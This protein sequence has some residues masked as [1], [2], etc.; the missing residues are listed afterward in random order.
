M[1][2]RTP[3][4]AFTLIELLV[5]IAIIAVL[6]G[7]LIP[8]VQKVRSAA[9]RIR[10]ANNLKQIGLA[11]HAHHDAQN[12]FPAGYDNETGWG[13]GTK[14]LPYLEQTSLHSQLI[15]G[16]NNFKDVMDIANPTVLALVRTPLSVYRCPADT[17]PDTNPNRRP[18]ILNRTTNV[19]TQTDIGASNYVG[20]GGSA[21]FNASV[22]P[23]SFNGVFVP[24][25]TRRFDDVT[26]GTS[27][28]LVVGEREFMISHNGALWA[29]TSNRKN[30]FINGGQ[31]HFNLQDGTGGGINAAVANNFASNHNGGVNFVMGDGS[32][33]FL[34][35]SLSSLPNQPTPNPTT[36][37]LGA[38]LAM[39]DGQVL[40]GDW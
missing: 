11:L 21:S 32:V 19:T 36:N 14:I 40:P 13:W 28:T 23:D 27:N 3:R 35:E 10:C 4:Q 7:L 5:V 25:L 31:M 1:S 9:D 26:D 8:A 12:G 30:G 18:T 22:A 33:R 24:N 39:N 16:S 15:A 38:L 29:G 6:I 2:I 17:L 20:V 34:R 37:T